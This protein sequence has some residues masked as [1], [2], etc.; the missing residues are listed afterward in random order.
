MKPESKLG[1]DEIYTDL[2]SSERKDVWF[3]RG[4]KEN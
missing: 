3:C 2:A 1:S 4:G